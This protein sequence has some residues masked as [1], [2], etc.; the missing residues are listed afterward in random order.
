MEETNSVQYTKCIYFGYLALRFF[1]G[2]AECTV[3]TNNTHSANV[4]EPIKFEMNYP[5]CFQMAYNRRG[6]VL[7]SML[8]SIDRSRFRSV[9]FAEWVLFVLTV[10]SAKPEKNE[11]LNSRN[12]YILYIV[13]S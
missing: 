4:T 9:T 8:I 13:L 7:A 11:V 12:I 1:S 3:S 5:F 10:H 6:G 2:L